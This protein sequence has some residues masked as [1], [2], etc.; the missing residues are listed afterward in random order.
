MKLFL[1]HRLPVI[2]VLITL[3]LSALP[4]AVTGNSGVPNQ[5]GTSGIAT[6][7][8]NNVFTREDRSAIARTGAD[9]VE[10]GA[11]YVIIHAT[12]WEA[13]QIIQL[14]YPVEQMVQ[15]ED[16]PPADAACISALVNPMRGV[17][18]GQPKS[19]IMSGWMKLSQR[20]CSLVCTTPEST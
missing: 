1:T 17:S 18:Y 5:S 9:I 11:T 7:W 15:T 8:V 12:E 10:I 3:V 6:Y 16:F 14:G 19:A 20:C 4:S 2:F 13:N